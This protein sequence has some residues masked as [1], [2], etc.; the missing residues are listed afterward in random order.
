MIKR[1]AAAGMPLGWA[2]ADEA[3][4]DNGPL[5]DYLEEEEI[6]YVLAVSR[7]HLLATPT[8]PQYMSP[9]R[10]LASM[11]RRSAMSAP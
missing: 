3:Q 11:A 2:A 6:A 9:M 5:R 1:A 7:D 4:L 8:L 10:R